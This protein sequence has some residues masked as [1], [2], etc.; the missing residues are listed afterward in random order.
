[1]ATAARTPMAAAAIRR[2]A[3]IKLSENADYRSIDAV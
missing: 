1:M 2:D 3:V